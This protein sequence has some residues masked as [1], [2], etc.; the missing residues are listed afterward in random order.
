L[1]RYLGRFSDLVFEM[2]GMVDKIA[3]D[4]LMA[5]WGVPLARKDH[6]VLACKTALKIEETWQS[7]QKED[8]ELNRTSLSIRIGVN[9]GTLL[10]GNVGGRYFSDY[11]V[12][13]VAVNFASRL[14]SLN[15]IYN[16]RI[17]IGPE[18]KA[19]LSEDFETRAVDTLAG[20]MHAGP[21]RIYELKSR[22]V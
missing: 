10:A 9:S 8:S 19:L 1:S 20:D 17:L 12:H 16:T 21:V 3:G 14:E 15:K 22:P 5:V 6:A 13:G 18:T 2:H 11:T 7:L 4:A